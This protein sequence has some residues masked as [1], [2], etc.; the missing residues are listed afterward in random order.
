L[1]KN[2]LNSYFS[3]INTF[4]NYKVSYLKSDALAAVSNVVVALPQAMACAL[5]IGINPVYGIYTVMLSVGIS[6]LFGSSEFLI[7]GTTTALSLLIAGSMRSYLQQD[8]FLDILFMLTLM[9]GIIQLVFG[10]LKMGKILN[11]VSHPV[12]LGFTA[13]IGVMLGVG[14]LNNLFGIDIPNSAGMLVPEKLY[15]LIIKIGGIN[16]PSLGIG[17]ISVMI[18]I[19]ARAINKRLPAYFIVIIITGILAYAF[20]LEQ[21]G[22]QLTKEVPN[23]IATFKLHDFSLIFDFNLWNGAIVLAIVGLVEAITLSKAFAAKANQSINVDQEFRAQGITNVIVSFFQ[24]ITSS[25]SFSNTA[26][27]YQNG[28]KTRVA[29]ILTSIFFVVTFILFSP[30]IIYIS[31]PALA[32][33]MLVIAY[34]LIDK[35]QIRRQFKV[36][37]VDLAVAVVTFGATLVLEVDKAVYIGVALSLIMYLKGTG[38]AHLRILVPSTRFKGSFKERRLDWI[39]THKSDILILQFSGDLYFG[40]AEDMKKSLGKVENFA[41]VYILRMRSVTSIDSTA[42]EILKQFIKRE[43]KRESNIIF[44]GLWDNTFKMLQKAE[45]TEIL[46]PENFFFSDEYK[47]GSTISALDAA[48][49]LINIK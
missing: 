32:G 9:V 36:G 29:G 31:K 17:V 44:T 3:F 20:R 33:V 19:C 30:L 15:S 34:N 2:R 38:K 4:K 45:I 39:D 11:Y 22:V 40:L 42:L 46:P 47:L 24:G 25:G 48:E 37:G 18:I 7:T 16:L 41:K 49:K 27:N 6:S 1:G 23:A 28:A 13:G 21:Y 35:K 26:A 12:L 5:I 43:Q 8:N 14:Q 10:F